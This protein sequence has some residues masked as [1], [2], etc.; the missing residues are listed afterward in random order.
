MCTVIDDADL[1]N[2]LVLIHENKLQKLVL[3]VILPEDKD[4]A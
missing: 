3:V 2:A 1:L 4:S